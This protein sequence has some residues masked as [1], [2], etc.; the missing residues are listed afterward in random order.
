MR[1]SRL[2]AGAADITT[3][4]LANITPREIPSVFLAYTLEQFPKEVKPIPELSN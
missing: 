3:H 4:V 2:F 1:V